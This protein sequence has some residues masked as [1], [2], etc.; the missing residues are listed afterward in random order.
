MA[1]NYVKTETIEAALQKIDSLEVRFTEFE[2]FVKGLIENS[3]N[4]LKNQMLEFRTMLLSFQKE[5]E[6]ERSLKTQQTASALKY[7][8][9]E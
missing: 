6:A 1:Q 7:L 3:E 8:K 5:L 2:T 4:T 9:S